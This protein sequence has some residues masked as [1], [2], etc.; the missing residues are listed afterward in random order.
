[1]E[2]ITSREA[3]GDAHL[4]SVI[5]GAPARLEVDRLGI[6][7]AIIERACLRRYHAAW[8]SVVVA[9]VPVAERVG[10][11][12]AGHSAAG[13]VGGRDAIEDGTRRVRIVQVPRLIECGRE[14]QVV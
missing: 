2:L 4:E 9:A 1:M 12:A 3:L 8:P 14:Q 7:E 10:I 6:V 5:G 13:A 11:L